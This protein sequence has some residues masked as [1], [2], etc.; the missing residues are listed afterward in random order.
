[1]ALPLGAPES[2][3]QL[4]SSENSPAGGA[5]HGSGSPSRFSFWD[6][7]KGRVRAVR[8][9]NTELLGLCWS[10]GRDILQRQK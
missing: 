3:S 1:M 10:I 7:L 9:A 4:R 5:V 8:A 6:F 2:W